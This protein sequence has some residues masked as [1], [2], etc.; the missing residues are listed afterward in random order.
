MTE[1]CADPMMQDL[2]EENAQ[3]GQTGPLG[4]LRL[5]IGG[6]VMKATASHL[7]EY[8]EKDDGA[9]FHWQIHQHPRWCQIAGLVPQWQ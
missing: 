5:M 8:E 6:Q 4:R 2:V 9:N 3:E 7:S 1:V